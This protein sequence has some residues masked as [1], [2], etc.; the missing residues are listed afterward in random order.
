MRMG[1]LFGFVFG[2]FS[3][4]FVVLLIKGVIADAYGIGSAPKI[5]VS[6]GS[7]PDDPQPSTVR[8]RAYIAYP[9]M[10]VIATLFGIVAWAAFTA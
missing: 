10:A 1:S 7:D 8:E 6:A 3:A 4:L 2:A 5:R 9:V